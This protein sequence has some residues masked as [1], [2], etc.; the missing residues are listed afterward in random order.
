MAN[1]NNEQELN[2]EQVLYNVHVALEALFRS[3]IGATRSIEDSSVITTTGLALI[4]VF[5]ENIETDELEDI[6]K[7]YLKANAEALFENP[8]YFDRFQNVAEDYLFESVKEY[9][10]GVDDEYFVEAEHEYDTEF[11]TPVRFVV[12]KDS[13][14]R[15]TLAEKVFALYNLEMFSEKE[16]QKADR[17]MDFVDHVSKLC[18]HYDI[19]LKVDCNFEQAQ[20][21]ILDLFRIKESDIANDRS[22]YPTLTEDEA[23]AVYNQDE[24]EYY[25]WD[26]EAEYRKEE[27]DI[28]QRA[29]TE[30]EERRME[31]L[32]AEKQREQE[33]A[34]ERFDELLWEEEQK[35]Q[36]EELEHR[37]REERVRQQE[38]EKLRAQREEEELQER[39][40]KEKE[41]EE[42]SKARNREEALQRKKAA[43][44]AM[45][46]RNMQELKAIRAREE[47][48]NAEKERMRE[49]RERQAKEREQEAAAMK[50]RL[51]DEKNRARELE[52]K[53]K[54][55]RT[56]TRVEHIR[57]MKARDN[58][59]KV[60]FRTDSSI[61]Q[62]EKDLAN[63]YYEAAD[64]PEERNK[65]FAEIDAYY[66]E[67]YI[68]PEKEVNFNSGV[69]LSD[70]W[71]E[72]DENELLEENMVKNEVVS[73]KEL[74]AEEGE[75]HSNDKVPAQSEKKPS[76]K[77]EVHKFAEEF[78]KVSGDKLFG[79]SEAFNKLRDAVST[80]DEY[81]SAAGGN[82]QELK[83]KVKAVNEAARQYLEAKGSRKRLTD[84]GSKRYELAETAVNLGESRDKGIG[85]E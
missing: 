33:E 74:A 36:E 22:A 8:S 30:A 4:D 19:T 23:T 53:E 42:R 20:K 39:R 2:D 56:I 18:S 65:I 51:E 66:S 47:R 79:N 40:R 16:A 83:E 80:A 24:I 54:E 49:L 73:F 68:E 15:A 21:A 46:E 9:V 38:E 43:E 5:E 27:K 61:T 26:G 10:G 7:E 11:R 45:A 41:E 3:D 55:A 59:Y 71:E 14:D 63:R 13:I 29:E 58:K 35:K 76:L 72:T 70:I 64:N 67:E 84:L 85:K 1:G 25:D 28:Q 81:A 34:K 48:E 82:E 75:K 44:D 32:K 69:K 31:E 12:G 6:A 62:E 57:N 77:N 52:E 17:E 50:Q 37:L 78:K 60:G